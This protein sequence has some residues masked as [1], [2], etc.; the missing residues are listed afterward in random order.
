MA[1]REGHGWWPYLLPIFL[2]LALGEIAGRF[3]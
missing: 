3:P 1:S 2:F